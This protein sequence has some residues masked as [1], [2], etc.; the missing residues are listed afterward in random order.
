MRFFSLKKVTKRW[1]DCCFDNIESPEEFE[2]K[3]KA[4][5]Q[6]NK[7]G[8]GQFKRQD[9]TKYSVQKRENKRRLAEIEDAKFSEQWEF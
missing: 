5:K 3:I 8:F 6:S 7:K 1:C 4:I 9:E 2:A